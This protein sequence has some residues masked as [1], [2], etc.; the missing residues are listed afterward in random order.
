MATTLALLSMGFVRGIVQLPI[1]LVHYAM[2]VKRIIHYVYAHNHSSSVT[3]PNIE[4]IFVLS[5]SLTILPLFIICF[6]IFMALCVSKIFFLSFSSL[7][8][9][10][11]PQPSK[12]LSDGR[13]KFR[14]L[15][16]EERE[17]MKQFFDNEFVD[18]LCLT[19]DSTLLHWY[20]MCRPNVRF[21]FSI[22]EINAK[23]TCENMTVGRFHTWQSDLHCPRQTTHI[24]VVNT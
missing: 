9:L 13:V 1:G 24:F 11:S 7:L 8:I 6:P 16:K 18:S 22:N 23:V 15:T 17:F 14:E 19:T 4:T 21:H 5:V 12:E 10:F 3:P 2:F 20:F